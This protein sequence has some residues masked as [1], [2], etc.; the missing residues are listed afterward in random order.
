MAKST[1]KAKKPAPKAAK[2]ASHR[3]PSGVKPIAYRLTIAPD[4]DR[5][6][7]TGDVEIDVEVVAG[8]KEIVLNMLDLEINA[9]TIT[10]TPVK[11][12]VDPAAE[13]MTLT[14]PKTLSKGK[15]TVGIKFTGAISEKMR[16]FYRSKYTLADGTNRWMGTTQFEA[17]SARRAFPCFDEP[18]LKATFEVTI[19]A[20]TG[21][22]AISNMPVVSESKAGDRKAFA[23][24]PTPKMSTYLL[25]FAVGEFEAIEGK[26]KNGV[27]VRVLTPPGRSSLGRF[28][29]ETAVRG[30]E[31]FDGYYGIP[32]SNA[33]PK[34]DLLAIPDFEAGA[35][36]NWGAITFRETAI[37][38]DEKKSSIPQKRR[39]A[40]VVLHELAHQWFG[41][42]V[43]PEWWSF[44]WLNESFATFMAFKATAELFPDWNIW[45]EYVSGTTSGGISLDSLRSSHPVEVPVGAAHE[46]EQIFDAISYN[47]G[48]SVLRQLEQAVGEEV[49][50]KG[51]SKYL[52]TFAY[53]VAKS[54]DLWSAIGPDV[55]K[56]MDGWTRQTGLPVLIAKRDGKG[57]TVSQE[58]FFIDRDPAKPGKDATTWTIPIPKMADGRRSHA[59][60][61]TRSASIDAPKGTK[62][63]AGQSGFYLVQYDDATWKELAASLEK[64]PALDRYGLQAD[65]YSLMRAGYLSVGSYLKLAEA[66]RND[67]NHNCWGGLAAGLRA[68]ADIYVG[69]PAVGRLTEWAQK[70]FAPIIEKV[71][72]EEKPGETSDRQ[73]LRMTVLSAGM[74]FGESKVVAGVKRRFETARRDLSTLSPNLQGVVFGGAARHGGDDVLD[75]LTGLYEMADLPEV[76]VRLLGATGAFLR[77]APLRKAVDYTL[78]SGKV[79]NQDGMYVF[80]SV[81]IETKRAAWSLVKEHWPT[82]DQR[83]GKSGMIGRFISLAASAVPS[84]DHAKDIEAFFKKNPAPFATEVIKQTLEGIRAR[85]KFR[86]RNR[87]ALGESAVP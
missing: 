9:A 83:Y 36:E 6:R 7:Y 48:G 13:R 71:G 37:Y 76:K 16:G 45:E 52:K 41:N 65:A 35:M 17:T 19:L 59:W 77:E 64:L 86:E 20:P 53:D 57:L 12:K 54:D 66:Y 10:R 61:K 82:L 63:N 56:M 72:W 70:L 4:L 29:L 28:A 62:L 22:T 84:E 49:F 31:W 85:A 14:A 80:S 79:R 42:L 1:P 2:K 26:T 73:L 33:V 34:C 32:Y 50:R 55:P 69:D 3:L 38:I 23:F 51:I 78:N 47:K 75:Q 15:F 60:L 40:E 18:A 11:M 27:P 87:G 24:A 46:V 25:Y 68:L 30:I 39:V 44:L 5:L 21:R 74:Y 58:R 81:P 8:T 43:S 67:E